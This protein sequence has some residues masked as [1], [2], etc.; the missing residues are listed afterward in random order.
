M[1]DP[2]AEAGQGLPQYRIAPAD[3]TGGRLLRNYLERRR[4]ELGDLRLALEREDFQL[5]ARIG[6]NLRGSGAAYQLIRISALGERLEEAATRRT[7]SSLAGIIADLEQFL[8]SVAID[9]PEPSA[10]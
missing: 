8:D 1:D 3:E 2:D 10:R 4:A 9:D 5:I 6:H 7:G